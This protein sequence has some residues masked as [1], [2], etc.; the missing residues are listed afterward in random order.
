MAVTLSRSMVSQIARGSN[1]SSMTNLPY[2]KMV[3]QIAMLKVK[4]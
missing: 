2:V 3:M 4:S 1:E